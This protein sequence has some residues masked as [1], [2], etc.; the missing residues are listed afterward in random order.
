MKTIIVPIDFSRESLNGLDFAL[1]LAGK[2]RANVQMVNI[3]VKNENTTTKSLEKDRKLAEGKFQEILQICRDKGNLKCTMTSK[4]LE[5]KIY[6]EIAALTDE[7]DD[8]MVVLSTHGESGFEELFIGG[9][10]YRIISHSRKPVIAVRKNIIPKTIKKIVLP[11]D[12][13]PETREKVPYTTHL[14]KLFNAEI[15]IITVCKSKSKTIA[16][17]LN[18]Y[19]LQVASS[20]DANN[21]AYKINHFIGDNPTDLTLDY[22][23][24]I[25][26][27][28]ISIMTEQE[29]SAS[30]LLLGSY[31]HQM[32]NKSWIPVLLFPAFSLG[33]ST[34]FSSIG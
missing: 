10:A 9:N 19:A 28:L 7:Y 8:S 12:I 11:L 20:L 30:N 21:V 34:G 27:D 6:T 17:K 26:A 22:A 33:K 4:I 32:I 2:N 13:T 1:M 23:R 5:G 15:H 24:S 3:V 25:D 16:N 29:K 14:A 31:A 18:Q